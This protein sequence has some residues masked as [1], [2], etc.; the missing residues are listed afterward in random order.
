MKIPSTG[1]LRFI[2]VYILFA[3]SH[4]LYFRAQQNR[5]LTALYIHAGHVFWLIGAWWSYESAFFSTIIWLP[6]YL[7]IHTAKQLQLIKNMTTMSWILLASRALITPVIYAGASIGCITLFYQLRLGHLPDFG[8]Y[9]AYALGY[10]KGFFAITIDRIAGNGYFLMVFLLVVVAG[11]FQLRQALSSLSPTDVAM[12]APLYSM[13]AMLIA[14]ISYYV[15]RSSDVSF[16]VLCPAFALAGAALLYLLPNITMPNLLKEAS[17][18]ALACFFSVVLLGGSLLLEDK[19]LQE[20]FSS[21]QGIHSDAIAYKPPA[22]QDTLSIATTITNISNQQ[23]GSFAMQ[24][25][26]EGSY[27]TQSVNGWEYGFQSWLLPNT[28]IGYRGPL[29][30]EAYQMLAERRAARTCFEYG[31]LIYNHDSEKGETSE[32]DLSRYKMLKRVISKEYQEIHS[33]TKGSRVVNQ[34]KRKPSIPCRAN[35]IST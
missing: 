29:S 24:A 28:V 12:L 33:F 9:S 27:L 14:V 18:I 3:Y 31:W 8:L 26:D 17:R 13:L 2:W 1:P 5:S 23:P 20:A 11:N 25:I 32:M 30:E 35:K 16:A 34:F 10:S 4:L 22:S 6:T 7:I 21:P 19:N 15:P